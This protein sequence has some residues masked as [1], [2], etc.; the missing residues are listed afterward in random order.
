MTVTNCIAKAAELG[1]QSIAIPAIS[2]GI[3]G[4][5]KKRC[6]QVILQAIIKLLE[7]GSSPVKTIKLMAND[8]ET[9]KYFETAVG[10]KKAEDSR[11][12]QRKR[13]LQSRKRRAGSF[14]VLCLGDNHT[15]GFHGVDKH[16]MYGLGNTNTGEE[17][18]AKYQPYSQRLMELI[19]KALQG[20]AACELV[21]MAANGAQVGHSVQAIKELETTYASESKGGGKGDTG[22]ALAPNPVFS[23]AIVWTGANDILN[24]KPAQVVYQEIADLHTRLCA[25]E[26]LNCCVSVVCLLPPFDMSEW[27]PRWGAKAPTAAQ[28]KEI[29]DNRGKLNA[30][31]RDFAR[32]TKRPLVGLDTAIF[33][34]ATQSVMWDDALHYSPRG[35]KKIGEVIFH[36]LDAAELFDDLCA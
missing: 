34:D 17:S 5:P 18:Q 31:L 35:Y 33:Q 11:R 29:A 14:R 23:V 28:A 24:G 36:V 12:E 26:G 16:T 32:D 2:S 30:L 1:C 3:F 8:A 9:V 25:G 10:D 20:R 13:R 22:A 19:T 6:C 27:V 15:L 7:A 4:F 21:T